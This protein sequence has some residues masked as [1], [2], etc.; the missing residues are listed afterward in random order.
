MVFILDYVIW[1]RAGGPHACTLLRR[2]TAVIGSVTCSMFAGSHC[3]VLP[4][5]V[6]LWGVLLWGVLLWGG[7]M[8]GLKRAVGVCRKLFVGECYGAS[9][10]S[11]SGRGAY[12]LLSLCVL[13]A[14]PHLAVLLLQHGYV[15][16][17]CELYSLVK[18]L[19]FSGHSLGSTGA[20]TLIM[21]YLS[22]G[23]VPRPGD[24]QLMDNLQLP[25]N[26]GFNSEPIAWIKSQLRFPSLQQLCRNAIRRALC[27]LT[28]HASIMARLLALA[29]VLPHSL[30]QYLT[31]EEY[32][33]HDHPAY[34]PL[35]MY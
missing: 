31:L 24:T 21:C 8:A 15:G 20:R 9:Q 13:K 11:F 32:T 14:W 10:H 5:G 26:H 27:K 29:H 19:Q 33:M 28:G 1:Y 30:V 12:S 7:R 2:A 17:P 16:G 4:W 25:P 3:G 18:A 34:R 22:G 35:T 6:L 23:H